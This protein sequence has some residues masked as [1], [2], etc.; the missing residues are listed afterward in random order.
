MIFKTQ[1]SRI[2]G[3][4]SVLLLLVSCSSTQSSEPTS[5]PAVDS[6][7][8]LT[9]AFTTVPHTQTAVLPTLTSTALP[10]SQPQIEVIRDIPY[11]SQLRL[12]VY[13]PSKPGPWSVVVALHGGGQKKSY[14]MCSANVSRSLA[15][16]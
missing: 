11:T 7:L 5:H 10:P 6:P 16:W 13:K 2:I 3:L 1:P 8:P 4:I 9:P 15:Q 12:D 14:L